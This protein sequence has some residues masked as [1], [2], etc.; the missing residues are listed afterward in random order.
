MVP[1]NHAD[2]NYRS[3]YETLL[4]RVPVPDEN[5]FRIPTDDLEPEAAATAYSETLSRVIG[6]RA[7]FPILDLVFLGMGADG[8]TASLFPYTSALTV[9]DQIAVANPVDKLNATRITLSV[10]VLNTSRCIRFLVTGADKAEALKAVL[11]CQR[12][13]QRYPSQ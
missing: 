6:A 10:P 4:S 11:E 5:I 13:T 9:D 8:H 2:S 7:G 1:H 12:D 3:A